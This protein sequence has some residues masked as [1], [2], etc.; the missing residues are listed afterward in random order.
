LLLIDRSS[1]VESL[2]ALSRWTART[3]TSQGKG[4]AWA[5]SIAVPAAKATASMATAREFFVD[6]FIL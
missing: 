2:L 6:I 4:C 3:R 1:P 5:A